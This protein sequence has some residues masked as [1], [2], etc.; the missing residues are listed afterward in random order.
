MDWNCVVMLIPLAICWSIWRVR[1]QSIFEQQQP[2]V[3]KELLWMF[4]NCKPLKFRSPMIS[5]LELCYVNDMVRSSKVL[6]LSWLKPPIGH[7]K[8]NVNGSSMGNPRE[9]QVGVVL[10]DS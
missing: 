2:H 3:L 9:S 10:W 7:Y 8:L 4:T 1:K 5:E 6:A